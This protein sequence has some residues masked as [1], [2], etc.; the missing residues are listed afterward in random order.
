MSFEDR[1]TRLEEINDNMKDGGIPIE[2][3]MKLFE[4]G[5][6]LASSLEKEIGRMERKVE[7]L[8]NKPDT[9]EEEPKLELF[10]DVDEEEDN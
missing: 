8:I 9:P 4:E 2:K 6:K 5:I 3:A 1:L 10:T 7:I